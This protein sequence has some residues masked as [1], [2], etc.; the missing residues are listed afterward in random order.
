MRAAT[1]YPVKVH[2]CRWYY[3]PGSI[4]K[5]EVVPGFPYCFRLVCPVCGDEAIT[6]TKSRQEAISE[7]LNF[8]T[9]G[10]GK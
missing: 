10:G 8:L 9:L 2:V 1:R 6:C 3:V 4:R 5:K 7:S